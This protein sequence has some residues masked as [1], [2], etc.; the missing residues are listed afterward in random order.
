MFNGY[1]GDESYLRDLVRE[2]QKRFARNRITTAWYNPVNYPT[3]DKD[4]GKSL[5]PN[6]IYVGE[7]GGKPTWD[8]KVLHVPTW[9]KLNKGYKEGDIDED[10][11][12][13]GGYTEEWANVAAEAIRY[14]TAGAITSSDFSA[15]SVVNVLAEL[16]NTTYK[17]HV[18]EQAV[19]VV[20]TPSLHLD[21]DTY[22]KFTAYRD[23]EE[24][25]LVPTRK[26]TFSRQSIDLK[27][28][29]SHLQFSDEVQMRG[30]DHNV[31][32]THIENAVQDLKRVKAAKIATELENASDVAGADFGARTGG[33]STNDPYDV[34][35]GVVDVIEANDGTVDVFTSADKGFRDFIGNSNVKGQ[36]A[37]GPSQD[38]GARVINNIQG[39][40]GVTWYIDN[41]LTNTILT[42]YDRKSIIL[43]QG[44]TK[45]AQYRN[46]EGGID[47][48]ISRDWNAVR[49]VQSGLIRNITGITA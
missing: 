39:Y 10:K 31:Y 28:D 32:Q 44:P 29:V 30:Y 1:S 48:Y 8:Q 2:E 20:S 49:I 45:V 27:K 23:I 22:T 3:K 46:E 17:E 11:A 13:Y 18:L 9:I 33:I 36:F 43:A 12:T 7:E 26:G 6:Y 14:K 19:W 4:S 37:P 38:F 21:I 35:G 5:E 40:S 25:A 34:I 16:L 15:I 41:L 42:V 24:G 47:G